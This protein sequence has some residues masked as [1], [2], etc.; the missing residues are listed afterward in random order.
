M[1][2][3]LLRGW[4]AIQNR[5]TG[6]WLSTL[7][8]CGTGTHYTF[9]SSESDAIWYR[10]RAHALLVMGKLKRRAKQRRGPSGEFVLVKDDTRITTQGLALRTKK[11]ARTEEGS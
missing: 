1:G 6:E 8:P 9:S 3:P 7:Q 11:E 10:T 2:T 5:T 4:Y